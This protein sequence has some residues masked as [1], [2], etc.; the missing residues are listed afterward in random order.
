MVHFVP[1]PH[2]LE[3]L[4]LQDLVSVAGQVYGY[5]KSVAAIVLYKTYKENVLFLCGTL[6]KTFLKISLCYVHIQKKKKRKKVL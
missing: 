6:K 1:A 3:I 4:C 5:F 2:S